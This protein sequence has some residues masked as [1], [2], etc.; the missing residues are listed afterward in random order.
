M[1]NGVESVKTFSSEQKAS[2]TQTTVPSKNKSDVWLAFIKTAQQKDS[3]EP[4]IL[5]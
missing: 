4:K 3:K 2:S 5:S 1:K